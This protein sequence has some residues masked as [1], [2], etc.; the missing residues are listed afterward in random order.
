MVDIMEIQAFATEL[1]HTDRKLF[2]IQVT[3]DQLKVTVRFDLTDGYLMWI[4]SEIETNY[5]YEIEYPMLF[6]VHTIAEA[7]KDTCK[8]L[9]N[10]Y[11]YKPIG[12]F[13]LRE[14]KV[15]VLKYKVFKK[16]MKIKDCAVC[17]DETNV[18]TKCNHYCCHK[19]LENLKICP[20]C[21]RDLYL[22]TD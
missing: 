5:L 18:Y 22:D 8:T 13:L 11:Y 12:K 4:E 20:I 17:F 1:F 16:F 6:T 15:S 9:D 21:N 3:I 19:C 14:D 10:L 7:I 2:H